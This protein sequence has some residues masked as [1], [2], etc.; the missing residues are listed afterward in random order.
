MFTLKGSGIRNILFHARLC[1]LAQLIFCLAQIC[2]K[3]RTI[4]FFFR[5][6]SEGLLLWTLFAHFWLNRTRERFQLPIVCKSWNQLPIHSDLLQNLDMSLK[7]KKFM[8]DSMLVLIMPCSIFLPE[9]LPG[10]SRLIADSLRWKIQWKLS[11]L[12]HFIMA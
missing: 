3:K 1:Y 7:G 2:V 5:T 4:F 8:S 9:A 12:K 11:N 6:L 10:S